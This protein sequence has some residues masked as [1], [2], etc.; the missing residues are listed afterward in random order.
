[1]DYKELDFRR[2][3][4]TGDHAERAVLDS[5]HDD[6]SREGVVHMARISR[7]V[8]IAA[9]G[10]DVG[11]VKGSYLDHQWADYTGVWSDGRAVAMGW[12]ECEDAHGPRP[13]MLAQGVRW[14]LTCVDDA[15]GV[16]VVYIVRGRQ[17]YCAPWSLVRRGVT[18]A[19]VKAWRCDKMDSWTQLYE[20]A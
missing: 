17:R 8:K 13:L 11:Q 10:R 3:T 19:E 4:K 6:M 16:A 5:V 18:W 2:Y 14:G 1:M 15:G 9:R 7:P 20:V 12:M